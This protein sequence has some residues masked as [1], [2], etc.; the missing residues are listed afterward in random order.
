MKS[1]IDNAAEERMGIEGWREEGGLKSQLENVVQEMMG[2][3]S[4]EGTA[5]G[6]RT[7]KTQK[8]SRLSEGG[9]RNGRVD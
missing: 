9:G 4:G 2:R 8:R 6:N 1:Q 3:G 7:L 5:D